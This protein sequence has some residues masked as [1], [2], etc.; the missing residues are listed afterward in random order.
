[1]PDFFLNNTFLRILVVA[2]PVVT[3]ALTGAAIFL[4]ASLSGLAGIVVFNMIVLR[5][6]AA[7]IK[8]AAHHVAKSAA[9]ISKY[10]ALLREVSNEEFSNGWQERSSAALTEVNKLK[11]LAHLFESR[12]NG[13]VGP[14]MNAFFL[15]DIQCAT[16]LEKWRRQGR[17]TLSSALAEL[18]EIDCYVSL[19][20]YAFN[21]PTYTYPT[22]N[23]EEQVYVG[24]DVAHPL[25]QGSAI[26][27][28]SY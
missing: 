7:E 23:E 6:R 1:M 15:F 8:E 14:L 16:R 27:R 11:K 13:M 2:V 3:L 9:V 18:T 25:L 28:R 10:E 26:S 12:Y 22:I 21:H 19:A 20:T 5:W 24:E 17:T 4:G